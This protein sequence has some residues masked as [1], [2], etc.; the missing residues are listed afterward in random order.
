MNRAWTVG[1]LVAAALLA[2]RPA[3]ALTAQEAILR[4]TPA[5]ALV[6][7]RVDAEV[8]LNCG[9]GPVTV[10]PRPF[11]ETGTGWFVDGRGW[12][13]TNAHVVDPSH[14]MPPWVTH[15]LKKSAIDLGCVDPALR[16]RGLMRGQN[17]GVEDQLRRDASARGLD[18]AKVSAQPSLI[19]QLSNGVKLPA[20]VKKFSAPLLLNAAG[21]PVPD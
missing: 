17:P 13:I 8:T 19:V 1:V 21:E 2:P 15:E 3:A 9:A 18:A 16:A 4:A 7:S 10:K 12:V 5:V 14:R 20:E 6:T 11:V